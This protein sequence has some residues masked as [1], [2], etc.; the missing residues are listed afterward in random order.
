MRSD[1]LECL[2]ML[3]TC[4][5]IDY[6]IATFDSAL[7]LFEK[8]VSAVDLRRALSR[9]PRFKVA[10]ELNGETFVPSYFS[11]LG[12]IKKS[13]VKTLNQPDEES[14]KLD[15]DGDCEISL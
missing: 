5:V 13:E 8:G 3:E 12:K 7:R 15:S 9:V 1:Y 11:L 6:S 4:A 10:L 2:R 14:F